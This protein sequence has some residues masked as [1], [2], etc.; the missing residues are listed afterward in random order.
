MTLGVGEPE[1]Q[2]EDRL[3]SYRL[4][5]LGPGSLFAW[6]A[7]PSCLPC[8]CM[9]PFCPNCLWSVLLD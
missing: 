3:D 8:F 4:F 5:T 7:Q 9:L 6:D 2:Q 1:V